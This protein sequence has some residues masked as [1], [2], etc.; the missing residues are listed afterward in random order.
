M[1]ENDRR[2]KFLA[3]AEKFAAD[4]R[5][6]PTVNECGLRGSLVTDD[7]YP[8]DID[9]LLV[10]TALDDIEQ[11]AAHARRMGLPNWETTV[12]DA[13]MQYLGSLCSRSKCPT[14]SVDCEIPRCGKPPHLR[15]AGVEFDRL[16]FLESPYRCIWTRD[17]RSIYDYWRERLGITTVKRPPRLHERKLRCLDCGADFVFAVGEQKSFKALGFSPP[18]RCQKCRDRRTMERAGIDPD[19]GD[20]L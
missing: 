8:Q 19:S 7:P 18:K 13:D 3:A 20:G 6:Y 5:G 4:I 14:R 17:D 10:V 16:I 1:R 2:V 9:L 15:Q 11:L 12:V